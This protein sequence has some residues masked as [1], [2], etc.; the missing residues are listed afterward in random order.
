[1]L[2]ELQNSN[3]NSIKNKANL[4]DLHESEVIQIET[5]ADST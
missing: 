3:A 5:F 1:M 4:M 2:I